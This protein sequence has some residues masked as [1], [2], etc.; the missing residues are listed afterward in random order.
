MATNA[1]SLAALAQTQAAPIPTIDPSQPVAPLDASSR[2]SDAL[3][4]ALADQAAAENETTQA[5]AA[6][7]P[8]PAPNAAHKALS[9]EGAT[10]TAS[11]Q[12]RGDVILDGLQKMRAVFSDAIT[13]YNLSSVNAASSEGLYNAQV[14]A[15]NF[16]LF[17]DVGSKLAGKAS[18]AFQTLLKGQ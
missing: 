8:S 7:Q 15:A 16:S 5:L 18:S 13:K 4:S 10:T 9:L 17:M 14:G 6:S 1:A 2:F 12:Q 11:S 3:A